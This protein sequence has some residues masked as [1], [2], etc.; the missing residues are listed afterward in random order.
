MLKK[1]SK[2]VALPEFWFWVKKDKPIVEGEA[3]K[4]LLPF[5]TTYVCE[6]VFF[7]SD[8]HY[9]QVNKVNAKHDMVC[10]LSTL[11]P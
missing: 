10:S 3:L 5:V 4:V 7:G 9:N 11:I 1:L 6:H 8:S 2:E